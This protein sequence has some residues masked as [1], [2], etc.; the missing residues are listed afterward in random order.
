M[1]TNSIIFLFFHN[2]ISTHKVEYMRNIVV[3]E[4]HAQLPAAHNSA[5][6]QWLLKPGD[7]LY[8][9][10]WLATGFSFPSCLS[11]NIKCVF[12]IIQ[13]EGPF[14]AYLATLEW[15][16]SENSFLSG[17]RVNTKYVSP[18]FIQYLARHSI[19]SNNK[20]RGYNRLTR[21]P[22]GSGCAGI[23]G[24]PVRVVPVARALRCY[25]SPP[26]R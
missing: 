12:A 1:H 11:H 6:E 26:G 5:V 20:L 2:A 7:P 21:L 4:N 22:A 17:G 18:Y 24:T 8:S 16:K 15:T 10:Q 9:S 19:E 23:A 13:K 14:K 25:R 3:C